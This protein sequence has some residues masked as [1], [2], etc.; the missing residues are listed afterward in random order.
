L[1][2]DERVSDPCMNAAVWISELGSYMCVCPQEHSGVHRELEMDECGS[3]P[4]SHVSGC[5]RGCLCNCV[6]RFLR[7]KCELHFENVTVSH[8]STEVYVWKEERTTLS[9]QVM[10]HRDIL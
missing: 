7:D 2:V 5:S 9:A 10:I 1:E 4:W 8:V 3:Q 6:S